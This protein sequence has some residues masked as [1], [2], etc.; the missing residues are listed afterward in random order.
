MTSGG[1][2]VIEMSASTS[3][4]T[5]GAAVDVVV[6]DSVSSGATV[7]GASVEATDD[8][9]EIGSPDEVGATAGGAVR[10]AHAVVN[11]TKATRQ[12]IT[13]RK[14]FDLNALTTRARYRGRPHLAG[15]W[16]THTD[17]AVG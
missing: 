9:V 15:P 4:V 12:R 14:G 10:E 3:R 13:P 5:T 7:V 2:D 6:G 17:L 1:T 8:A 11:N 16:Q